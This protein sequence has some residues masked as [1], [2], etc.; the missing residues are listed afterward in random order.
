MSGTPRFRILYVDDNA[1]CSAMLSTFLNA[2]SIETQAAS[3]AAQALSMSQAERFDLYLLEAWLPEID[4]FELC[5]RLRAAEPKAPILFFS[6]AAYA[7]DEKRGIDAGA[8][9]YVNKPD[10]NRLLETITSFVSPT[11]GAGVTA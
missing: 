4:G 10:I 9:A 11:K 5:R 3:T 6:A 7:A 8:Q 1:D 2:S